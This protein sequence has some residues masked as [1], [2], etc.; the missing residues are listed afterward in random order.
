MQKL[1]NAEYT[2]SLCKKTFYI[3]LTHEN[4]NFDSKGAGLLCVQG[5][6]CEQWGGCLIAD[7]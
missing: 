6:C 2:V 4:S 1:E 3:K 7:M 5:Q